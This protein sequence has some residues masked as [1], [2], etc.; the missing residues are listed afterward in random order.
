MSFGATV[1]HEER[2]ASDARAARV[3]KAA[4]GVNL[5]SATGGVGESVRWGWVEA[6]CEQHVR[7]R[8]RYA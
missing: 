8:V 1:G 5:G 3:A 7:K 4:R 2:A 6:G